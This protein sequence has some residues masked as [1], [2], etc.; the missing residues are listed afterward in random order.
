MQNCKFISKLNV[1]LNGIDSISELKNVFCKKI[2]KDYNK[3]KSLV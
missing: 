3:Y 1:D 2:E